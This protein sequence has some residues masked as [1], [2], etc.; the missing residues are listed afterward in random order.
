ME[1]ITNYLENEDTSENNFEL[2]ILANADSIPLEINVVIQRSKPCLTWAW[3]SAAP[4]FI[5]FLSKISKD[6]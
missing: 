1:H 2:H 5:F 4:A 3:H 6:Q